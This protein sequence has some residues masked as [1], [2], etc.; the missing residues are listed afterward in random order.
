MAEQ[1]RRKLDDKEVKDELEKL[2]GW[3][4]NNNQITK[5]YQFKNYNAGVSF[6]NLCAK[7]AEEHDHHPDILLTYG[8]VQVNF[9]T[10]SAGGITPLDLQMAERV[11]KVYEEFK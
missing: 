7:L 2:P 6:T 3:Q 9:S 10:H 1:D 8:K 11:E 4:L 5:T